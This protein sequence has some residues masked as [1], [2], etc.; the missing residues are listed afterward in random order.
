MP[1]VAPS[2][3][4]DFRHEA[5]LYRGEREFLTAAG[6]FIRD[7][8]AAGEPMLVAVGARKIA[9]LR[10][11][12]GDH[13]LVRFA[14]MAQVG[15][16]PARIIPAW[17]DFAAE[18]QGRAIRGIGEPIWAGRGDDEIVESQRHESL[19]NLAFADAPAFWLLCPYDTGQ[20]SPDVIDEAHRS[21]PHVL[22]TGGHADSDAYRGLDHVRAPFDAR[23]PE[24]VE[25][26]TELPL[27]PGMLAELRG[28]VHRHATAAGLDAERAADLVLAANEVASNSLMYGGSH[29]SVRMWRDAAV[30]CEITDGGHIAD[31]LIGR[32]Q[33][34]DDEHDSR[35]VWIANQ[36]CDLVQMRSSPAGT[37][38]RLHV[39]T[40]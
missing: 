33:P 24:P 10:S 8:I 6:A 27:R 20:L 21:H 17:H 23:L 22:T 9:R 28:F 31:P 1:T 18:H 13:E 26:P 39:R 16:N 19:L 37:V 14:D 35:G 40:D 5:L 38:T 7:G 12:L 11:T 34:G 32:R 3:H 15:T 2:R 4:G 30:V 36:L 29:G 25:V